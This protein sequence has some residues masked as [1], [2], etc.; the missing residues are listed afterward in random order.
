MERERERERGRE[1]ECVRV[2]VCLCVMRACGVIFQLNQN[3]I[4]SLGMRT[5]TLNDAK[6]AV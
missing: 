5:K 6:S 4:Y 3:R 1:S 2:C